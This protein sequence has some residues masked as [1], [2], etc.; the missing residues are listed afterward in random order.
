MLL[1]KIQAGE[2]R[3]RPERGRM[4]GDRGASGGTQSIQHQSPLLTGFPLNRM[5]WVLGPV[6]K[7]G[8]EIVNLGGLNGPLHTAKPNGKMRVVPTSFAVGESRF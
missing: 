8:P 5:L 1:R 7:P 3:S 6:L 2:A 4:R